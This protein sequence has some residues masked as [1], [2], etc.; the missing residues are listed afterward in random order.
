MGLL[1]FSPE[2]ISTINIIPG[3]FFGPLPVLVVLGLFLAVFSILVIKFSVGE[4]LVKDRSDRLLLLL[5]AFWLVLLLAFT[6]GNYQD[7]RQDANYRAF[8]S[9][10]KKIIRVCGLGDLS[11][12]LC[13]VFS[14]V[15]PDDP[16]LR[17]YYDYYFFP[18]LNH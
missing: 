7:S 16:I 3:Y 13:R 6:V 12:R 8:D 5:L 14:G 11:G 17:T 9:F 15:R 18:R 2:L 10:D 1:Q 4:K